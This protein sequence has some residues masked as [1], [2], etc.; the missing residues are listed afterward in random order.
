MV[1]WE[2]GEGVGTGAW[3]TKCMP[4]EVLLCTRLTVDSYESGK[5]ESEGES[6]VWVCGEGVATALWSTERMGKKLSLMLINMNV[7]K[8][9][10]NL[11]LMWKK[12]FNKIILTWCCTTSRVF[13]E[14]PLNLLFICCP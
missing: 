3:L 14:E 1:F 2:C 8:V 6:T 4:E 12:Q 13:L 10:L 7:G 5:G 11:N 9:H